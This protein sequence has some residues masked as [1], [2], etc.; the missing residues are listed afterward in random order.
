MCRG[1]RMSTDDKIL[2]SRAGSRAAVRL[3]RKMK[4][5]VATDNLN[6]V[7]SIIL[8]HA[9]AITLM[10]GTVLW[11]DDTFTTEDLGGMPKNILGWLLRSRCTLRVHS[12][13]TGS[14]TRTV[15]LKVGDSITV[16]EGVYPR[17]AKEVLES[18]REELESPL[19]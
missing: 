5:E 3:L 16:R 9:Q 2:L 8:G 10:G 4:L 7:T 14:P 12:E 13:G 17:D 1:H 6:L 11:P 18:M 15:L 19:T